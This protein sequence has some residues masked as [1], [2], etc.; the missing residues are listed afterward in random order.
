MSEEIPYA[1]F[2][3]CISVSGVLVS[4]RVQCSHECADNDYTNIFGRQEVENPASAKRSYFSKTKICHPDFTKADED[5][6]KTWEKDL[7]TTVTAKVTSAWDE[8][9]QEKLEMARG[10]ARCMI[11]VVVTTA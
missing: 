7:R 11:Y 6:H 5:P 3:D 8:Y 1:V 10:E 2:A 4:T 9:K